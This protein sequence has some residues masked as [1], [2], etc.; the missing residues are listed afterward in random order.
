MFDLNI[1]RDIVNSFIEENND[2]KLFDVKWV[3]EF[4]YQILQVLLDKKGGINSDELGIANDYISTRLDKYESELPQ[5]YM[6]EV[7]SPGAEKPLRN[8]EEVLENVGEKIFARTEHEAYEG[9]L[10]SFEGDELE[11]KIN[12]KGRIK[13]V[14]VKY[15]SILE[16]RLSV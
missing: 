16:I 10:L 4:G 11:I 7:S 15:S 3:N 6:L 1:V 13:K 8:K 9:I 12:V 2:Y 5:N 14:K